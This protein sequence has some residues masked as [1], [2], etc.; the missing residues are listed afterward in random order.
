VNRQRHTTRKREHDE[1][2]THRPA[3][4]QGVSL[5]IYDTTLRD[6]AQAEDVSFSADDKVRVAQKLDELG[7]HYIEGGWPGANPKDIEFFRMIKTIPLEHAM[8]VAFGSTRKNDNPVHKDPNIQSLLAADTSVITLFGKSWNLHV[9][10]ALGISLRQN[11]EIIGDSIAYLRS[12]NR[13][14]FYDAEHFFDGYKADP[15]YALE[16]IRRAVREGAERVILCDTNGGTMPWEIK[17][18]CAVVQRECPVPLGIH[19]HNDTEMAVANSLVAIE[20]GIRQV[21]G[22]INGIGERCGNANLCS[23]LP[24]LELKMKQVAL[25]DGRLAR[26][27]EVSNFVTEIAN[28]MPNKHQ[29]YV[30][31][32]AFAHKGGVHIHAVQKNPA[33]YEHVIPERVGNRQRMLISDYTG[34]SGLLAKV[35]DYGI[36][37]SKQNPKVRELLAKLKDLENQGYQFEGAEGSFELLMRKAVGLHKPS[38]ELLGFRVIVEKRNAS[39]APISEATLMVKV[40]EVVEHTAAVGTGPVNALDHALRKALEK[41]YPQLKEVTLLDYKVRVLAANRGTAARVRV[42]LESGD[43]KEKWG[44]VGVSENIMEASWQALADSIEYKLLPADHDEMSASIKNSLDKAD[45]LP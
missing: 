28:L 13:R 7:V 41:F 8:V 22:T 15:E 1:S 11:L 34:Q 39:E 35:E 6:G 26:L 3:A 43:H 45:N 44:T 25:G 14:V 20:A 17:E 4:D 42:L 2:R 16:T 12:K 33:T 30:G 29:P 38:F 32:A 37:L 9:T 27:R 18:T 19:A 40:G 10:E 31:D 23:I 5:E 21:Q 36:K 24:N